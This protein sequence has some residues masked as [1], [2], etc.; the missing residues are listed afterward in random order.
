MKRS[1][2]AFWFIAFSS[3]AIV[4]AHGQVV[5]SATERVFTVRAGG[6]ASAF[7]PDYAGEGVA[8]TSPERLYGLGAYVDARFSRWVQPELEM[9]WGAFNGYTC[10]GQ[11]PSINENTYSIGERAP[12]INNFHKFT[13]YGKVLAGFGT[14]S[15]LNGSAFVLTFGG[16]VDYRLNRKFTIRCAD[17]EYQQWKVN[18]ITIH[19]YGL[20]VGMSYKVF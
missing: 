4:S 14:G 17:F 13:P 8:Q 19:P 6:L 15:F 1:I 3:A 20:S 18:P 5:P 7:Q 9:R 16:G 11:C 2:F 12:I 10:G